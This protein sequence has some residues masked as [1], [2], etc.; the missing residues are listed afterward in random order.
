MRPL[1]GATEAQ[2]F[3][4]AIFLHLRMGELANARLAERV[5]AFAIV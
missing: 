1:K 5:V 4:R 2:L 3:K